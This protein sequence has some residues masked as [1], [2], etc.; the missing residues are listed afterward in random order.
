MQTPARSIALFLI[1]AI[2]GAVGQYLY[3]EG[4]RLARPDMASWLINWRILLGMVCY[5]AVMVLFLAAFRIGGELTV[6]YPM[7]ASTFIWALLIGRFLLRESIGVTR[8]I[9]VGVIVLGMFLVA[10]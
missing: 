8:I 10:R 2:L 1:A 9:G 6:L 7:Y 5:V 3:R 4:A